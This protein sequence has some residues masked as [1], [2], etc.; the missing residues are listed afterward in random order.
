MYTF[1]R[2]YLTLWD[3]RPRLDA[4]LPLLPLLSFA[5]VWA[6]LYAEAVVGQECRPQG[7]IV[8]RPRL[9]KSAAFREATVRLAD[10]LDSA[11]NGTVKAGWDVPNVSFSVAVVSRDQARRDVPVWEYHHLGSNSS[12][13]T[14]TVDRHSQYLIGSVSK[15]FTVAVLL[16]SGLDLDDPITKYLPAL[17]GESLISWDN[18][19][20]RALASQLS[21]IP[22]NCK[23]ADP[24]A[25]MALTGLQWGCPSITI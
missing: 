8:P 20:L 12:S 14:R 22:T 24:D 11:V 17:G 9:A 18:I 6:S 16:R 25:W 5:A 4:M 21:G 1:V 7:P 2:R 13:G 15:T 19:T 23:R 3:Y 10:V